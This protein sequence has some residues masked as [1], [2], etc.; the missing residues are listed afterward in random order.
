VRRDD[1]YS[2]L[3][4]VIC[5]EAAHALVAELLGIRVQG[6][7][8]RG[9]D[10]AAD[11]R[12]VGA[13][14]QVGARSALISLA[15][16]VS[17]AMHGHGRT[18]LSWGPPPASRAPKPWRRDIEAADEQLVVI[19]P[20]PRLRRRLLR[21][22]WVTARHLLRRHERQH[23]DVADEILRAFEEMDGAVMIDGEDVREA[24]RL[25]V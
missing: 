4:L 24:M 10:R 6:I 25:A 23:A 20:S 14:D 2:D 3:E 18:W 12:M 15:G 21:R 8:V 5:H 17:D 13:W 1:S 7:R 9:D 19:E 22:L 11:G 16:P